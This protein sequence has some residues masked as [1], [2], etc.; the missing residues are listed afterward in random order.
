MLNWPNSPPKERLDVVEST[1]DLVDKAL[2]IV[3]IN[4]S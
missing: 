2:R 3:K 4:L 1:A